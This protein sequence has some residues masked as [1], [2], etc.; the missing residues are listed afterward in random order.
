MSA[1]S[2]GTL[3][4]EAMSPENPDRNEAVSELHTGSGSGPGS[5]PFDRNTAFRSNDRMPVAAMAGVVFDEQAAATT[6]TTATIANARIGWVRAVLLISPLLRRGRQ[7]ILAELPVPDQDLAEGVLVPQPAP[8]VELQG[9]GPR[10]A[11]LH[12]VAEEL[13]ERQDPFLVD[14]QV[15]I[16][17]L[18][19]VVRQVDV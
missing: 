11:V 8:Q 3:V 7:A 17:S 4:S 1:H 9:H 14:G 19:G 13:G 18:A 15:R 16:P 6:A 2:N 10:E 12:D 5:S